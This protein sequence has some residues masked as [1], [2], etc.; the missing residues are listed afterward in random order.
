MLQV[1]AGTHWSEDTLGL[2]PKNLARCVLTPCSSKGVSCANF[3]L[4]IYS[5]FVEKNVSRGSAIF[6]SSEKR[7]EFVPKSGQTRVVPFR[8]IEKRNISDGGI[9]TLA[10]APEVGRAPSY[11][12]LPVLPRS[13]RVIAFE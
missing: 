1:A 10:M 7:V 9:L 2:P 12:T 8:F 6:W 3:P 4:S 13:V 11:R 5:V